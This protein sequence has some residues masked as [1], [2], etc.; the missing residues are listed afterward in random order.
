M[1]FA[2]KSSLVAL[3]FVV[4]ACSTTG[5][6]PSQRIEVREAA[7]AY[8]LSVPISHLTMTLPRGNWSPKDKSALG[9]GTASPRYFY[10]EDGKEESL[11]LSGWFEP[12]SRFEGVPKYWEQATQSFKNEPLNVSFEKLG[13]WD[14]VMYDHNFGKIVNTHLRAHWVQSGTWIDLHLSTTTYGSSADNRK[15]LRSLLRGISIAKKASA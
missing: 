5:G 9:G 13:G 7:D 3:L 11:I 1:R 8:R 14:T 4:S 12:D 15:K 2:R 10:F 6:G